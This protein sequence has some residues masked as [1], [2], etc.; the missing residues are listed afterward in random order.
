MQQL[1]GTLLPTFKGTWEAT[2]YYTSKYIVTDATFFLPIDRYEQMGD[3]TR[4]VDTN[5]LTLTLQ[6]KT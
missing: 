5:T 2:K 6:N 3:P 1:L 4:M